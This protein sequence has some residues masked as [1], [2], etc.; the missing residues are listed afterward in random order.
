MLLLLLLPNPEGRY[1]DNG[2]SPGRN[3]QAHRARCKATCVGPASQPVSQPLV[4]G[5]P[6]P[7]RLEAQGN[8]IPQRDTGD[9]VV[10]VSEMDIKDIFTCHRAATL[11][12]SLND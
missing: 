4:A 1:H 10:F 11:M 6:R 2:L 12:Y 9:D 5:Q 8:A 3:E 7:G